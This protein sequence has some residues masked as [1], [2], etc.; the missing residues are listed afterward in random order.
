MY[1]CV[2]M[3]RYFNHTYVQTYLQTQICQTA[4]FSLLWKWSGTHKQTLSHIQSESN[5]VVEGEREGRSITAA[6]AAVLFLH[7]DRKAEEVLLKANMRHYEYIQIY[8]QIYVYL[9]Q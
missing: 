3:N 1:M 9:C 8:I 6:A 5:K 4:G 7:F 2:N